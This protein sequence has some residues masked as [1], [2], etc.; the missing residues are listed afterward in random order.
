MSLTNLILDYPK[1]VCYQNEPVQKFF[2]NI[3]YCGHSPKMNEDH[4]ATASAFYID[5]I[6]AIFIFKFTART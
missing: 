5:R 6:Y 4:S 1:L 2:D 3:G